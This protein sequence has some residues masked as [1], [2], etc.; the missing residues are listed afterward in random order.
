MVTGPGE[1]GESFLDALRGLPTYSPKRDLPL[2]WL[3]EK[4]ENED[5]L[6]RRGVSLFLAPPYPV[7]HLVT[8]ALFAV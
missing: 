6:L 1:I 4:D 3:G 7:E 5:L 2:I 8:A